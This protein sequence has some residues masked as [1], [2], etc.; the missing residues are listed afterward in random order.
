MIIVN[1]T[2]LRYLP[3]IGFS[4]PIEGLTAI[5][6]RARGYI[7]VG[8]AMIFTNALLFGP[9]VGGV[10]GGI[11]SAVA[12]FISYPVFAPYTLV[13]KGFEGFIAGILRMERA[14]QGIS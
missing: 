7:N 10:A 6:G 11:G 3:Q 5:L 2:F 13:I 14:P 8:D 9:I 1:W 12:D 4:I